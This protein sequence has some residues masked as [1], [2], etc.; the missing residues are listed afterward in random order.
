MPGSP[1]AVRYAPQLELLRIAS[2]VITHAG[3][4]TVVEALMEGTPMIAIPIAHD[5]PV[6]AARLARLKLAEVL[7]LKGLSSERIRTAVVK[8]LRDSRYRDSAQKAGADLRL[9]RGTGH[10]ADIIEAALRKYVGLTH[11]DTNPMRLHDY[12]RVSS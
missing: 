10:A 4:N 9:L 8:L 7:Q 3:L 5:Q 6:I 1:L 2:L 11:L 12:V